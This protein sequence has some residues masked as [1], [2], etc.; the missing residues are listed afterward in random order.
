EV[1]VS[2]AKLHAIL[3][4][5]IIF[6]VSVRNVH[7]NKTAKQN[8]TQ[9]IQF[10]TGHRRLTS[11]Q[12]TGYSIQNRTQAIQFKTG[13]RLFNSKQDTGYSIQNRTQA[14]QFKTGHRLFN[15][16]QDTGYSI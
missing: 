2:A 1:R 8:R 6:S 11:K 15:S 9:A 5:V 12:D 3:S 13:H 4:M 7:R 10:T 16:K 14:I